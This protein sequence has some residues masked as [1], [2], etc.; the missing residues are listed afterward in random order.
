MANLERTGNFERAHEEANRGIRKPS[1]LNRLVKKA[2]PVTALLHRPLSIIKG[3]QSPVSKSP[4][5]ESVHSLYASDDRGFNMRVG[6]SNIFEFGN[7][8]AYHRMAPT[9]TH[10]N[11]TQPSERDA[12]STQPLYET[13]EEQLQ[14]FGEQKPPRTSKGASHKLSQE[15]NEVRIASAASQGKSSHS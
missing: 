14:S 11:A 7:E 15:Q 8:A 12:Y 4:M 2:P 6:R 10:G 5:N 1:S 13:E 3:G 9:L